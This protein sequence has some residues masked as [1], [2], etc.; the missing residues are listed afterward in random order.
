[1]YLPSP[2]VHIIVN[3]RGFGVVLAF[4]QNEIANGGSTSADHCIVQVLS[5]TRES[6]MDAGL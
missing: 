5:N 2:R 3:V 1:M 6:F 4:E